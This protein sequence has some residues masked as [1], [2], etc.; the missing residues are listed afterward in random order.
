MIPVGGQDSV[1]IFGGDHSFE[2]LLISGSGDNSSR[3]LP[4]KLIHSS[5]VDKAQELL[6]ISNRLIKSNLNHAVK[7]P[8]LSYHIMSERV[9]LPRIKIN[10][11]LVIRIFWYI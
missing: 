3:P 10:K 11:P 2:S 8:V 4:G 6:S 9:I 5:G 1:N 7:E